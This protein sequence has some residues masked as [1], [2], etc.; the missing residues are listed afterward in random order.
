MEDIPALTIRRGTI[1]GLI[2]KYLKFLQDFSGDGDV[3]Q[4][5]SAIEI[6]VK[7]ETEATAEEN[8]RSEVEDMYFQAIAD[9]E[10]I[11]IKTGHNANPNISKK[12]TEESS[13]KLRQFVD[14]LFGHHIKALEAI[15][16]KPMS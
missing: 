6:K 16:Y 2:T 7:D 8:H 15:G 3:S 4:I 10:K 13:E 5:Q 1:K 9:S 14:K 12:I 11:L